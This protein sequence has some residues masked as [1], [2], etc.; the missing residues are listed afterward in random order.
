MIQGFAKYSALFDGK[1]DGKVVITPSPFVS[2]RDQITAMASL[3]ASAS[4]LADIPKGRIAC[5]IPAFEDA[6]VAMGGLLSDS[7]ANIAAQGKFAVALST[8]KF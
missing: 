4:I 6:A 8:G 2:I 7:A 3:D 5:V 1:I